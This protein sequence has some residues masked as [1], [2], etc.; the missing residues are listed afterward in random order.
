[1]NSSG[2]CTEYGLTKE[3]PDHINLW[4]ADWYGWSIR[5][6][7]E[8]DICNNKIKEKTICLIN[9]TR[10]MSL[11]VSK[12]GIPWSS[13]VYFVFHDNGFYFFSNEKSRHIQDARDQKIVSASVFHDSDRMEKIFG[14]QMSGKIDAVTTAGLYITVVKKY[15]TK[16]SFLRQIFGPKITGD[17][18]F[19]LEKFK[20]RLYCFYP[21]NIFLSDNSRATGK[22]EK[23]D[24]SKIA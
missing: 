20:S 17:L 23:I 18:N 12:D 7:G 4:H 5:A 9:E 19:F 21:E 2:V 22:R 11:A 1:V 10:V 13:P 15:V 6:S 16:F 3:V 14:L 24:L 8:N